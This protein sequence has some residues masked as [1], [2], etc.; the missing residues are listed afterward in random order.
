MG[1][2]VRITGENEPYFHYVVQDPEFNDKYAI[3]HHHTPGPLTDRIYKTHKIYCK[4]CG[5]DW[6][7]KCVW[8]D[9]RQ[10]PIIKCQYFTFK[11]GENFVKVKK[12]SLAPF[13]IEP[14]DDNIDC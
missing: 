7:V 4:E 6:G 11:I 10:Y 13:E 12:W 5:T 9:R 2:D 14:M 8:S 1:S 3:K